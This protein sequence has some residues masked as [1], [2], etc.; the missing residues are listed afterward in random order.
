MSIYSGLGWVVGMGSEPLLSLRDGIITKAYP[1][2][3]T[4][5]GR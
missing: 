3:L 2:I 5:I 4:M 1:P